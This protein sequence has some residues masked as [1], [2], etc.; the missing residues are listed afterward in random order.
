MPLVLIE[1]ES[2]R[3]EELLRNL[4]KEGIRELADFLWHV[5]ILNGLD[6]NG[7]RYLASK[8]RVKTYRKGDVVLNNQD[9][10]L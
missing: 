1:F 5:K 9:F 2:K 8:S 7:L 10:P 6:L 4:H 3:L